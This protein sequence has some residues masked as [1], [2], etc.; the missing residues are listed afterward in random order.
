M[1]NSKL[2]VWVHGTPIDMILPICCWRFLR[3]AFSAD[4]WRLCG[5]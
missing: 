4:L 2:W 3:L 1:D 5:Y